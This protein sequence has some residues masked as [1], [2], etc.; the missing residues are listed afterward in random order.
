MAFGP[1]SDGDLLPG[2]AAGEQELGA[3][4]EGT[5]SCPAHILNRHLP[6][7]GSSPH[8]METAALIGERVKHWHRLPRQL[9]VPYPQK[10]SRPGWWVAAA[11]CRGLRLDDLSGP[12]QLSPFYDPMIIVK[13]TLCEAPKY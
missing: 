10:C 12:F 11:Q 8:P 3:G 2:V 6:A 4:T 9:W 7:S 1:L 13:S 5:F